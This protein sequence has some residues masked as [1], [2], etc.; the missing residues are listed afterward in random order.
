MVDFITFVVDGMNSHWNAIVGLHLSKGLFPRMV[1]FQ[2]RFLK[3]AEQS[4]LKRWKPTTVHSHV[5]SH[6]QRAKAARPSICLTT[7]FLV[8]EDNFIVVSLE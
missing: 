6:L 1:Y 2:E 4:T 8:K 3:I 7:I 5:C